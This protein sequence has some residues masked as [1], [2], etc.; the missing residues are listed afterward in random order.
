M[1]A[2]FP[3]RCAGC[4]MRGEQICTRCRPSIPWL[5]TEVCPT[6]AS[7]TRLGRVCRRCDDGPSALDGARAAC[8]F[9]G[10]AKSAIH[11]LKFRGVRRRAPLLGELAAEALERRPLTIDALVPVPLSPGRRRQRGFNQSALIA[12]EIGRR[13]GVP[14]EEAWLE[15][16]RET[17]PQVGRSAAERRENV[18]GAFGCPVPNAV[19]GRR[20]AL[21]DDVMTTGSTLGAGAEVLKAAGAAR[22]YAVVVARE[23]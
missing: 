2:L 6:C 20:I 10:L 16:T 12:H 19:A 11:D 17:S 23:V 1:D 4:G 5:G 7:P 13:I 3:P 21:V 9:E 8:R 14:V 18:V 22:V 15:R